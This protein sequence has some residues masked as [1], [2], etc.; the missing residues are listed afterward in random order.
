M[1]SKM[2]F[3]VKVV[4]MFGKVASKHTRVASLRNAVADEIPSLGLQAREIGH[5]L[6]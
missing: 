5:R 1:K 6:G 4:S 2:N 3:L